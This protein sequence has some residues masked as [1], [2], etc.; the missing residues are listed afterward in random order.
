MSVVSNDSIRTINALN[1]FNNKCGS[2]EKPILQLVEGKDGSRFLK[3]V[4]IS[5]V[6]I[7]DRIL[8][9][10]GLGNINLGNIHAFLTAKPNDDGRL[11]AIEIILGDTHGVNN[12]R[13]LGAINGLS[14]LNLKLDQHYWKN[15]SNRVPSATT[16]LIINQIKTKAEQEGGGAAVKGILKNTIKA[17]EPINKPAKKK[18]CTFLMSVQ[19]LRQ[20]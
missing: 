2:N 12:S 5:K 4:D 13:L 15:D 19:G 20:S 18:K 17:Q 6:S 3:C 7:T 9:F 10:F 8:S 1:T 14:T 11:M 16:S